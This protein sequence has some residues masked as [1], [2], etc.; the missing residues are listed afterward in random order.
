MQRRGLGT[1]SELWERVRVARRDRK[2][3]SWDRED[4]VAVCKVAKRVS[5]IGDA[6]RGG[7]DLPTQSIARPSAEA[8]LRCPFQS[9]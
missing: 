7:G 2:D 1:E 6:A 9:R 5:S 8:V 3:R 4:Q